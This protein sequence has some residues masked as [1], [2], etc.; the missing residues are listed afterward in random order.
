VENW[1]NGQNIENTVIVAY[2]AVCLR[3]SI[4]PEA[5]IISSCLN[6]SLDM[7][8]T[9]K[10]D[11]SRKLIRTKCSGNVTLPEVVDH[12]RELARDPECP[13]YLDVLL[14]LSE[15]TSLPA[16][17]QLQ[18][19]AYEIMRIQQRVRFGLCAVVAERDALY[20]MLRIFAV[21]AEDYFQ[22]ISVFRTCHEAEVWLG[23]QEPTLNK[24]S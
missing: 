20:G 1:A 21:T 13:E 15:E 8:V 23:L 19:V 18:S 24:V 5:T 14:D 9:Y 4:E 17:S 11:T 12:F 10:I 3:E 22:A 6:W 2:L 7:P 16:T